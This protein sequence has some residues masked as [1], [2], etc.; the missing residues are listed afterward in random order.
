MSIN[1]KELPDA[2]KN[3]S[4]FSDYYLDSLIVEQPQWLDTPDIESDYAAIKRL[5]DAVAPN[6][7]RLNEPQTE[8]ELIQPLLEQLEH[9]FEVQPTLQTPQGAKRPDYAFFGS[10][11]VH[12][13]AQPHINTN[14]FFNTAL[15]VGD[16]K[17]WSRNLD[18][19]AEGR[20]DPFNNQNPNY[21]IDFYLRGA[22]K[23]WGVLTNGRQWRL[24]HRQTSY[25]MDSFYEVDLAALLS[26][27]GDLD[28]F[29]Y[30]YCLFRRD[31]FTPD[32]SGTSFLDR[33]LTESRQ[34]TI[35][36]SDD[37]KNRVYDALRLLIGGFLDFPRNGFDK[38]NPRLDEI[39][40]NALI[41]LYRLLFILYA[42]SRGLL[43]VENPDYATR[44]SLAALA[45]TTHETLDR[46]EL[47][48]RR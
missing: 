45:E 42:E 39:H 3:H 7:D 25:R 17:A 48:I 2:V 20:G 38:A 15:A 14:R 29:R 19:K 41:L 8:R 33:V 4:L 27:N 6:A 37:L 10:T 34:H 24:Y 12:E 5:F 31:A 44:Y 23:L 22:D 46:G 1:P 26:G 9:V 40:A 16:A 21:Q 11:D 13:K 32:A 18:R 47:I 35:A 36:V 43:P 28:S 30:F